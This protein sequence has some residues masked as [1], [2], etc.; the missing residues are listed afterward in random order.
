L[1][2]LVTV[3]E[4]YFTDGKVQPDR[5][6]LFSESNKEEDDLHFDK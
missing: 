3:G 5:D 1:S 6:P 4:E 2:Y